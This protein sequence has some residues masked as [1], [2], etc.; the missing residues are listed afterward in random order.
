M[1]Q[2]CSHFRSR[3]QHSR[4]SQ[5]GGT[6]HE[7]LSWLIIIQFCFF[8]DAYHQ[9]PLN[10]MLSEHRKAIVFASLELYLALTEFFKDNSMAL[11]QENWIKE[12]QKAWSCKC[13]LMNDYFTRY[14]FGR[15]I[16]R[17]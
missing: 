2:L 7:S 16:E 13:L 14:P 3:A 5:S 1:F 10:V 17:I 9:D 6:I 12:G 4:F 11:K 8:I 15:A